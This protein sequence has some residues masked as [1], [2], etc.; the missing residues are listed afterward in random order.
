MKIRRYRL[1]GCGSVARAG[2]HSAGIGAAG[3]PARVRPTGQ[4]HVGDWMATVA[5]CEQAFHTLAS[6]LAATD[7]D[8]RKKSSFDRSLSCHLPD[9]GVIFGARLHD[10][11]LSDI[12]EVDKA[13]AQVKL[14]MDS[15]DLVRLVA[16][17][18]HFASAWTSGRVKVD[19][20]IFD[21]IKL[22][23]IF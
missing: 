11:T 7:P 9:L 15:D 17:Q 18:L 13:D 4:T 23:G 1:S 2:A 22:R 19:A 8:T 12:R 3:Q 5:E 10:G 20:S 21:L 16:G 14:K 6:R